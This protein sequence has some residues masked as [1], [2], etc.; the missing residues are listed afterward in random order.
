MEIGIFYNYRITFFT[1][2]NLVSIC[3]LI[4]AAIFLINKFLIS[5]YIY[6]TLLFDALLFMN[7]LAVT[8]VQPDHVRYYVV[9]LLR[10]RHHV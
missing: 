1:R 7:L 9:A 8:I 6:T 4:N 2:L 10:C 3:E 5:C